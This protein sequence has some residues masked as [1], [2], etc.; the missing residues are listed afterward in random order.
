[1]RGGGRFAALVLA[2][3]LSAEMYAAVTARWFREHT[4][5]ASD[6]LCIIMRVSI[7]WEGVSPS[8]NRMAIFLICCW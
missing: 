8:D 5:Q 3:T 7:V 4:Q 2:I 6:G 1:M